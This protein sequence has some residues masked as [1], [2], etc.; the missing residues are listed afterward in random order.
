M[1]DGIAT[2]APSVQPLGSVV[3][4][5]ESQPVIPPSQ[6]TVEPQVTAEVAPAQ[7]RSLKDIYAEL[8]ARYRELGRK[9]LDGVLSV[10]ER[11]ERED[12]NRR[13]SLGLFDVNLSEEQLKAK[14]AAHKALIEAEAMELKDPQASAE[15]Y[16]F[17]CRKS[18]ES[19]LFGD[20]IEE[21]K[22]LEDYANQGK[23]ELPQAA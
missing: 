15:R 16:R 5:V 7:E 17:L 4:V 18:L 6:P 13:A 10:E 3:S 22:R 21:Y 23:F 1:T 11:R 19:G 8:A 14:D 9:Q 2:E 20:E 12:L